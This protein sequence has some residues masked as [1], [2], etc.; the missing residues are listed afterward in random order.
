VKS[1][2]PIVGKKMTKKVSERKSSYMA[3]RMT[4]K[5]LSALKKKAKARNLPVSTFVLWHLT[6]TGVFE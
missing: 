4:R 2:K 6:E 5:E 3:F 1:V